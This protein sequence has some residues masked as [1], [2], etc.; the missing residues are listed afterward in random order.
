MNPVLQQQNDA[1]LCIQRAF[2]HYMIRKADPNINF[3]EEPLYFAIQK[4][5]NA[6]LQDL[7]SGI[8]DAHI[9]RT[10]L[11][12]RY[13]RDRAAVQAIAYAL[14]GR[15]AEKFG[16]D[17]TFRNL[18]VQLSC[19]LSYLADVSCLISNRFRDWQSNNYVEAP[20]QKFEK[21]TN[22]TWATKNGISPDTK[23]TFSHGGSFHFLIDFLRGRVGGCNIDGKKDGKTGI[24]VSPHYES[25]KGEHLDL[26]R[27][28]YYAQT[29]IARYPDLSA[30]LRGTIEAKYLNGEI[31]NFGY[32][33][34]IRGG[35][36]SHIRVESLETIPFKFDC[37]PFRWTIDDMTLPRSV[38]ERAAL[39]EEK[40]L[41]IWHGRVKTP[42]HTSSSTSKREES[43]SAPQASTQI[44]QSASIPKREESISIQQAGTQ[45]I[46]RPKN[47]RERPLWRGVV[48]RISS[49]ATV[50]FKPFVKK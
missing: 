10:L 17:P 28:K 41:D 16:F 49:F 22:A 31:R 43:I 13:L 2:G 34:V 8:H 25:K 36:A 27:D 32:E 19:S 3:K 24:W 39:L 21:E 40:A 26:H 50:M 38:L 20:P 15:I 42:S 45:I 11:R 7:H 5:K 6:S 37:L 48:D 30:I 44:I 12:A 47:E 46:Q 29:V 9:Q 14:F 1:A 23:I 35:D 33:A 18:N 4:I